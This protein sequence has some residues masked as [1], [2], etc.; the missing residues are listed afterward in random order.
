MTELRDQQRRALYVKSMLQLVHSTAAQNTG[1]IL[2]ILLYR[3]NKDILDI[4]KID[5][6]VQY[7]G[8]IDRV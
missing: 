1:K 4:K 8:K 3:N 5:I 6:H 2:D 7:K